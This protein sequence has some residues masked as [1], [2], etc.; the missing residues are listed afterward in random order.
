[1]GMFVWLLFGVLFRKYILNVFLIINL[2]E[3]P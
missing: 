2:F 3:T 1:M